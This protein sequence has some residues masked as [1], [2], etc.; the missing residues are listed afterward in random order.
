MQRFSKFSCL[1]LLCLLCV[2]GTA[3]AE[4]L[5]AQSP[6]K[7]LETTVTNDDTQGEEGEE[8][9]RVPKPRGPR[10]FHLAI[11]PID[12][13]FGIYGVQGSVALSRRVALRSDFSLDTATDDGS[14]ETLK[15]TTSIA[16]YLNRVFDG[17]YIEPGQM[18]S[19]T[20]DASGLIRTTS[21][22]QTLLGYHFM[23]KDGLN[24]SIAMGSGFQISKNEDT[25]EGE[26]EETL[27][28]LNG[29]LRIGYAF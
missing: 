26:E 6:E 9:E 22:L 21:S 20:T 5:A 7:S 17:I 14:P 24:V 2:S 15:V 25:V 19:R 12:A 3:S 11:N 4:A 1:V 28:Y 16:I 23:F 27:E 13:A 10:R 8:Q 29:Y 18:I